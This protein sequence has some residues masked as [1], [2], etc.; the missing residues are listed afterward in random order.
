MKK[1]T[2]TL[3]GGL[4]LS[5]NSCKKVAKIDQ[6]K[7][8]ILMVSTLAGAGGTAYQDGTGIKAA[9]NYP[10]SLVTDASGNVFVTDCDNGSIRKITPLGVVTTF[11]GNGTLGYADGTGAAARF[12]GYN[13]IAIDANN[14][15]YVTDTD[16][17]CIRKITPAGVVTTFAGS[18]DRTNPDDGP[19]ATAGFSFNNSSG[20]IAVTS[21]NIIYVTD[22]TGIRKI[23]PD[24]MVSTIIQVGSRNIN[25][26]L[27]SAMIL[28]PEDIAVD[29][30]GNIYVITRN[31]GFSLQVIQK[32][33]TNGIVSTY[34]GFLAG[35]QNGIGLVAKF[36]GL[37]GLGVDQSGNVY[38]TEQGNRVIRKIT[39]DA[40]VSLFVGIQNTD[41]NL[42]LPKDG[43]AGIATFQ[44]PYDI[45]IDSKG[46]FYVVERAGGLIR[47]ISWVDKEE[48]EKANWN[49]PK[50]WK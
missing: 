26:P 43:P 18:P 25:G 42:A 4:L 46:N 48:P 21:S 45:T 7:E 15:L 30:S 24:G 29:P 11:A 47:K 17:R 32:I 13:S 6:E 40:F 28:P 8:K 37:H 14:N 49:R 2:L 41:A 22:D 44:D 38:T 27:A 10:R 23:T 12:S 20:G 19:I 34:A 36:E 5:M 3:I 50:E 35:Y 9:F 1:T 39:P 31:N 16:N 33:S